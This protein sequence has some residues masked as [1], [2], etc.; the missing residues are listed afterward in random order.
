LANRKYWTLAQIRAKLRRDLDLESELFVR[1]SELVDYINEAISDCEALIHNLYEMYFLTRTTI[2]MVAGQEEYTL[3]EN[4]YA[5]KIVRLLFT[6]QSTS[7]KI[8]RLAPA[9]MF[10]RYESHITN[11]TSDLYEYFLENPVAAGPQ[12]II[13]PTPRDT[14][15]LMR[16]WYIRQANRLEVDTDVCDIPEFINFIFKHVKVSVYEKELH[17]NTVAAKQDLMALKT[18]MEGTL[19]AAQPDSDNHIEPDLSFYEEMN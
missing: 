5:H 7:Y 12:V 10:E 8:K 4:I 3:P 14:G 19:S 9:K 18:L 2:N 15:P 13:V 1:Q 6:Q 16:M 17:P 11:N